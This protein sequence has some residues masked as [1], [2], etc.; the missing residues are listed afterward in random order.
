M[1]SNYDEKAVDLVAR[2]IT[3]KMEEFPC[4]KLFGTITL[5]SGLGG[6]G[7]EPPHSKEWPY[8]FFGLPACLAK[9]H[10]GILRFV[11]IKGCLWL[12]FDGRVHHYE[13]H[14][15]QK[16]VLG[17]R[18]AKKAGAKIHIVTCASG[19]INPEF[20]P[21]E[22]VIINDHLNLMG[23]NP[24][25][26]L[27]NPNYGPRFP[28]MTNAYDPELISIAKKMGTKAKWSLNLKTGVYA[29]L[30]G[31]TYETPAEVRMLKVLG[32]DMVGMSTV[33]EVIALRHLGARVLGIS[34]VANMAAGIC[35]TP[36]SHDEV[37][38]NCNKA[39]ETFRSLLIE[40]I[41]YLSA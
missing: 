41:H 38:L 18:A 14:D 27:N 12:V 33:P 40:I 32:A 7:H 6:F 10:A 34:C 17:V 1:E 11:P 31:P 22:L 8:E 25:V 28:D 23:G 16:I 2:K 29:A 21:G 24:L 39:A 37:V 30:K 5:G 4:E 26:G 19:G 13:G 3:E 15:F 35:K 9:G 20:K 36:L